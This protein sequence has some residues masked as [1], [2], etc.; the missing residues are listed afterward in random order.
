MF[1]KKFYV[2]RRNLEKRENIK[3]KVPKYHIKVVRGGDLCSG[4]YGM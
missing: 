3:P 1:A 2:Y 4:K